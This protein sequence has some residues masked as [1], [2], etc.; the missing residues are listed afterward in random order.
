[1]VSFLFKE[2]NLTHIEF[3]FSMI[4]AGRAMPKLAAWGPS[5]LPYFSKFSLDSSSVSLGRWRRGEE[6]RRGVRRENN[7]S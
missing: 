6:E 3:F 4:Q 1:M 5:G 2:C 7:A